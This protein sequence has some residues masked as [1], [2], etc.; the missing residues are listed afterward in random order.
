MNTILNFLRNDGSI[1]T[2]NDPN[3]DTYDYVQIMLLG[4]HAN[5]NTDGNIMLISK[6]DINVVANFKWYLSKAGY[7]A[8]Y[9]T[10]DSTIKFPRP[11]SLHQL[12]YPSIKRGYVVDHIN[13]NK[14]DNR[15]NNL[16]VCTQSQNSYNKS[17]PKN[18]KNKYKGIRKINK[19]YNHSYTA[20]ITKNG[21]KYEIKNINSEYEA[22]NIYDMMAEELFGEYAGKNFE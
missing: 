7:P 21:K 3:P 17:K 15:R 16:R 9:G 6:M 13:R 4:D 2:P 12:L 19:K 14:L 11:V 1:V 10:Y 20:S 22:A 8:T 5:Q 18:S